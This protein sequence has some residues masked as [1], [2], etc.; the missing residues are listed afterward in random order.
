MGISG[1]LKKTKQKVILDTPVQIAVAVYSYAKLSLI[2][3]WEFIS[4]FLVNDMYQ[5]MTYDTDS[6]YLALAG[7]LE[8]CVKPELREEWEQKKGD[9]L[10][11][12]DETEIEFCGHKIPFKT[13]DKRTPGKYKLEFEEIGMVCLNSKVYHIWGQDECKTSCKGVQ[14][15]RNPLV[16]DDF[17]K[18]L[19]DPLHKNSVENSGFIRDGL[20]IKTYTQRKKGLGY[21]YGK[22]KV[23][24]DGVSTTH[25]DI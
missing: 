17:L 21:F 6:L 22:R 14:K 12:D 25:L 3:F 10:T 24:D 8:E 11:S 23:L 13:F 16:R 4:Y 9:F 15:R 2:C 18:M 7:E 1:K 5:L 20:E 19:K